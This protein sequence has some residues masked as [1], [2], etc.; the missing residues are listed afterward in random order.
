MSGMEDKVRPTRK[1]QPLIAI[2]DPVT[3]LQRLQQLQM[4]HPMW[5]NPLLRACSAG[6][7]TVDDLKYL[8]SQYYLYSRNFTR[9]LSALMANC[10]D[11]LFRAHLSENLWEE[12]G[13]ADPDKRHAQLFRNFLR[14]AFG[15]D[16]PDRIEFDGF[17]RHFMR[18]YLMFCLRGDTTSG[19]AFLAL[20]TEGIVA[21][22]YR[23]LVAGLLNAGVDEKILTFFHIH[24]EC[25]DGH[26]FTLQQLMLGQALEPGWSETCLRAMNHALDLRDRFFHALYDQIQV[27]RVRQIVER[28]QA[29]TSLA[30]G[31]APL[32]HHITDAGTPLYANEVPKLNVKFS[33]E[34]LPFPGEVLD[35]RVVRIPPGKYNEKHRHAHET[36]FYVVQGSGRMLIDDQA[37]P[38]HAGD[39]VFAPRWSLHQSQNTGTTDLVLLAITDF[40][41]T[42]KAFVGKYLSTAR[43]KKDDDEGSGPAGE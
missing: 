41:L 38:V 1:S 7:L 8:F 17:T 28:I 4:A 30:G 36:I 16:D 14:D 13:G 2:E 33:V 37:V 32:V 9:Y 24:M 6:V 35:P 18:E 5:S 3:A 19:A 34:R 31:D 40:G 20:G 22:L 39:V 29:R 12:G 23:I 27:R 21:P 42:G 11:D 15:I 25:D 10:D 26:A 43:L